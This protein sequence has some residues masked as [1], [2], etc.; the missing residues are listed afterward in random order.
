MFAAAV[1]QQYGPQVC[2]ILVQ[3]FGGEAAR[4]ELDAL[5]EPLKKMIF[6][7]PHAKVWLSDALS[8]EDFPS[9]KVDMSERRLWLQRIIG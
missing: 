2:H 5:A 7:Q 6:A 4:S 9:Q 8:S 1:I 3:K